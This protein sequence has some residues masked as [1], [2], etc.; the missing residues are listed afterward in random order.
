M[1]GLTREQLAER[2][3]R[4]ARM[5]Q[6]GMSAKQIGIELRI[7]ARTVVRVRRA[8]GVALPAPKP[9]TAEE[10]RRANELLDDG[11]SLN[12]VARTIGRCIDS[13][14][15]HFPGRGWSRREC[16]EYA[17]LVRDSQRVVSR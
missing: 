7:T 8:Q 4:I 6:Q 3:E 9:L 1:K 11:Y 13:V 17:S 10:I 5:T 2:N 15:H 16:S 12:E 14:R